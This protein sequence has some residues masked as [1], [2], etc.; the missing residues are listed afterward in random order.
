[1]RPFFCSLAIALT[2]CQTARICTDGRWTHENVSGLS[3]DL[4]DAE[5]I[6]Y[7]GFGDSGGAIYTLGR[8]AP[9]YHSVAPSGDWR[10][11]NGNLCIYDHGRVFEEL[12]FI[13]CEGSTLIARSRF[14]KGRIVRFKIYDRKT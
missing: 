2:G 10:I 9:Q 4:L 6:E 7:L 8:K 14:Q 12:T 1:M 3:L 11:M 5:R 13:R